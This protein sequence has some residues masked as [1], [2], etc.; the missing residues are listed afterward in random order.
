MRLLFVFTG[1]TIG[2]TLNDTYIGLDQTKPFKLIETYREKYGIDFD[3]DTLEPV[4]I[5][6]ENST[7]KSISSIVSA[8]ADNIHSGYDGIIV[9]H[10]TDTIQYT[11]AA[12]G[13]CLGIRSVPV[14]LVSA[15]YPIE[16][17]RSNGLINLHAAITFIRSHAVG[18]V[19]VTYRNVHEGV[20][21]IHRATRLLAHQV[22]S[23][24]LYSLSDSHY[25]TLDR[26]GE[27][28]LNDSFSE[29]SDGI[30]PFGRIELAPICTSVL[31]ISS[32]PGME[33]PTVKGEVKH[34]ILESF[35]SGTINTASNTYRSFFDQMYA[36]RINVYLTGTMPEAGYEST[37]EYAGMHIQSIPGISPIALYMKLWI[38]DTLGLNADTVVSRSL[39]GDLIP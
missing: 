14:C 17:A 6:S 26:Y 19:W 5:L 21:R 8:V 22:C 25:G 38:S 28:T 4:S 12:L 35:H 29:L 16:D 24:D 3:Y 23:A 20:T 11:A 31:R 33:Y 36:R 1:G 37:N 34:V 9:T 7:G 39:S 18:G 15:D 10:G 30:D 13:Y 2:S 27:L 32:F